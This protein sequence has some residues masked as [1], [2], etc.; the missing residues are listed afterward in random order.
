MDYEITQTLNS[1]MKKKEKTYTGKEVK[2]IV[3]EIVDVIWTAHF[4]QIV[5]DNI[6][7]RT[8][9]KTLH[10]QLTVSETETAT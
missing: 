4:Q 6:Q 5:T 9:N 7:L 2:Q 3:K 10:E 8:I 1:I